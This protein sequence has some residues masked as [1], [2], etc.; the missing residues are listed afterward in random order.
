MAD[1]R[2]VEAAARALVMAV[3]Q[4]LRDHERAVRLRPSQWVD[5]M[6]YGGQSVMT[7]AEY[8]EFEIALKLVFPGRFE[9]LPRDVEYT[10]QYAFSLLDGAILRAALRHADFDLRPEDLAAATAEIVDLLPM[11]HSPPRWEFARR[12]RHV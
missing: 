6:P 9:G 1:R 8:N 7:L 3:F 11:L 5:L 2:D 4:H 10:S 12:F